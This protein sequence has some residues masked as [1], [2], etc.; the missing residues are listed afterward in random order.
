MSSWELTYLSLLSRLL[1]CPLRPDRT[2]VGTRGFFSYHFT[3]PLRE[4]YPLLTTKKVHFPSI[5][6]ELFWFLRG[7]TNV[8]YLHQ[9][10]VTIWDEWADSEGELG[11]IYGYQW[12]KWPGYKGETYDQIAQVISGLRKDPY[13][14]RHV[15]SA[16]NVA[17]LPQMAL[18]PCHVLFQFYV[19]VPDDQKALP[20]RLSLQVYQRSADVFLGLPFNV[21]SYALLLSM[22]AQCVGMQPHEL[23]F[24]LGDVHL[25]VTHEEVAR[26]QLTRTPR[27]LP[28][29]VLPAVTDIDAFE[30]E[31]IQLLDYNPHPALKAPI[32]V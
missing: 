3:V 26:V 14:R 25:Y 24:T 10:R 15:V 27:P 23:H 5:L 9:H 12:R 19:E 18:A 22:V 29:L 16:W 30:P 28:R 7:D 20:Q 13:S 4:G 17:H 21:A 8:A 1:S 2:A 6:Y 11:P 31:A 32:A